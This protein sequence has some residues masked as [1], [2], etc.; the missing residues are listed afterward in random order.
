M[1]KTGVNTN[2]VRVTGKYL[3]LINDFIVSRRSSIDHHYRG[4][5]E[6]VVSLLTKITDDKNTD[7]PIQLLT[8]IIE[9]DLRE[10]KKRPKEFLLNLVRKLASEESSE[11][12][13][14]ELE[15]VASALNNKHIEALS[16]IKGE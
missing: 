2:I 3:D 5:Q 8:V 10:H 7:L 9:R 11:E 1:S 12:T 14:H 15:I 4:K 6:E 16:K 13:L